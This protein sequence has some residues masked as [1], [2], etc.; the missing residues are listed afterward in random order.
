MLTCTHS[1]PII[2]A[3]LTCTPRNY[4]GHTKQFKNKSV[5]FNEIK[6]IRLANINT[7]EI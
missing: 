6:I 1:E 5:I 4:V 7:K 3:K 2:D